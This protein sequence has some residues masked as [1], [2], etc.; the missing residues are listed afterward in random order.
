LPLLADPIPSPDEFV[1]G[2]PHKSD[3]ASEPRWD[4][5]RAMHSRKIYY[6][7]KR[8]KPNIEAKKSAKFLE[9]FPDLSPA[10][11]GTLPLGKENQ[12]RL[13]EQLGCNSW[14]DYLKHILTL[15]DGEVRLAGNG[16]DSGGWD[17]FPVSGGM[18][19][20]QCFW[21][22]Q[23]MFEA[24]T[25]QWLYYRSQ[26]EWAN[27][28]LTDEE[29]NWL[30]IKERHQTTLLLWD[31]EPGTLPASG[32]NWFIRAGNCLVLAELF[33]W[34]HDNFSCHALY[35]LWLTLPILVQRR[36]HSQSQAPQA[37]KV[38]NARQ[39]KYIETGR[40]GLN[41]RGRYG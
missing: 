7:L 6:L 39:L 24:E 9:A 41:E 16:G 23:Y 2:I 27:D 8:L 34:A 4:F 40:W 37:Q 20:K 5:V 15:H 1:T 25:R 3:S 21:H 29:I 10:S 36:K 12:D 13:R 14:A 28:D 18:L 17:V 31:E 22:Y 19:R 33:T 32:G 30:I 11:G 38:R 35:R 26:E